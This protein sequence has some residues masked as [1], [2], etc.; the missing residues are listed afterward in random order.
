MLRLGL[1]AIGSISFLLGGCA[2]AV[3]QSQMQQLRASCDFSG[4]PRFASLGSV[5][6]FVCE[7]GL[8]ITC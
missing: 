8:T 4:D 3:M 7:A 6:N 2:Q 5:R 1:L